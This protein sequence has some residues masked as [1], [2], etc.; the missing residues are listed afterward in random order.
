MAATNVQKL[1]D[2]R[3]DF[4]RRR[5]LIDSRI[6]DYMERYPHQWLAL[7]EGDEWVVASAIEGLLERIDALGKPRASAVFRHLNPDP[8]KFGNYIRFYP[9]TPDMT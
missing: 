7:T 3:A 2:G 8:V 1:I 4:E 9:L 5:N 6:L